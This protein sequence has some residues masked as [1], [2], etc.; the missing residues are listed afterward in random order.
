MHQDMHLHDLHS[1]W[2]VRHYPCEA[3]KYRAMLYKSLVTISRDTSSWHHMCT[4][5]GQPAS[6]KA[7]FPWWAGLIIALAAVAILGAAA[8]A[9][10]LVIRRRRKRTNGVA[11]LE[12]AVHRK[13]F[14]P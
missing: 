3:A 10:C 8:L 5:G 14:F 4:A 13:V 2:C 11:S 7:G 6:S 1:W 9:A 12:A